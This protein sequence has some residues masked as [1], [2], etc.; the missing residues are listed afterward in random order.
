M[1]S[2]ILSAMIYV[3]GCWLSL[4]GLMR[5]PISS[6]GT[7]SRVSRDRVFTWVQSYHL[8]LQRSH[9]S[10]VFPPF[11]MKIKA[12][13]TLSSDKKSR[14]I[15]ALCEGGGHVFLCQIIPYHHRFF[16]KIL[17]NNVCVLKWDC[18]SKADSWNESR[19]YTC[20]I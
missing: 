9:L 10:Y 8:G 6:S 20:K 18:R 16:I 15:R 19:V 4:Q 1:S 14:Q 7:H 12:Q 3:F 11:S 13:K 2:C 5:P 17:L